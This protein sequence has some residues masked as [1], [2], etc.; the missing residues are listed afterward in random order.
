MTQIKDYIH[1]LINIITCGTTTYITGTQGFEPR[2]TG[3]EP[4][5]LPLDDVPVHSLITQFNESLFQV[6]ISTNIFF[7]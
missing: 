2:L 7:I 3:S 6:K 4:A 1:Q 5:V